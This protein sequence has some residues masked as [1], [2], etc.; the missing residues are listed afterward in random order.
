MPR[1]T[2]RCNECGGVFSAFHSMKERLDDC[3]ECSLS[4][5]LER[6]PASFSTHIKKKQ[7]GKIVKSFIDD[8]REEIKK[9]KKK[10]TRTYEP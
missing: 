9:E 6:I 10:M 1:Y 7:A 2:Y 4:G 8:T 3:D 5:T